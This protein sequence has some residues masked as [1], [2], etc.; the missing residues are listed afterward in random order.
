MQSECG[1]IIRGIWPA[2]AYLLKIEATVSTIDVRQSGA[3]HTNVS[4]NF[5][6]S[7]CEFGGRI[8]DV[9]YLAVLMLLTAADS[10]RL[11]LKKSLSSGGFLCEFFPK[12]R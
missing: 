1:Q 10:G 12:L 11:A 9:G 6:V 4:V 8:A 7:S 5:C 2:C 3:V